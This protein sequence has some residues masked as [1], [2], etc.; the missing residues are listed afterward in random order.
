M[1]N[2]EHYNDDGE[3][4]RKFGT[5]L[6]KNHFSCSLCG[7]LKKKSIHSKGKPIKKLMIVKANVMR[8]MKPSI[9]LNV[10]IL[11]N[12][13]SLFLFAVSSSLWLSL[14]LSISS[15]EMDWTLNIHDD[16]VCWMLFTVHI[17]FS[18][19]RTLIFP[20]ERYVRDTQNEHSSIVNVLIHL[21]GSW[22]QK[23]KPTPRPYK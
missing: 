6:P 5:R 17:N 2:A 12:F 21:D 9:R 14:F 13:V 16:V 10:F 22:R 18:G 11:F 1:L 8:L 7:H 15:V 19:F 3:R 20:I 23:K 4:R